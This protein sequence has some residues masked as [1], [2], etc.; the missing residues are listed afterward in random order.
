MTMADSGWMALVI[1]RITQTRKEHPS[2]SVTVHAQDK[3]KTQSDLFNC[4]YLHA[5]QSRSPPLSVNSKS[6][7]PV[8]EHKDNGIQLVNH[9]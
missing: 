4:F 1:N 6:I 7:I 9:N 3:R 2:P 8:K 5:D